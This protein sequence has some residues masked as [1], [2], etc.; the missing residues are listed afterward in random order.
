MAL[1]AVTVSERAWLE[2]R[3]AEVDVTGLHDRHVVVVALLEPVDE[4]AERG[5]AQPAGERFV[6][7]RDRPAE[8]R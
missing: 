1:E 4:L 8:E 7:G 5:D 6:Q 2:D 3:R